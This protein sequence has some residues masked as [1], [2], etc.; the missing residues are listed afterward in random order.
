MALSDPTATAAHSSP[1]TS[2]TSTSPA[3]TRPQSSAASRASAAESSGYAR[4][5]V[6][7]SGAAAARACD[8]CAG[9]FLITLA[10]QDAILCRQ[11]AP[12]GGQ[13]IAHKGPVNVIQNR[14]VWPRGLDRSERGE[15][16]A[17]AR[18]TSSPRRSTTGASRPGEQLP[19]TRELARLADVNPLTA[20]RVYRRLRELGYLSATV[21]RGTFVRSLP[22]FASDELDDDWQ[23][24]ALPPAPAE[25]AR[26][27]APGGDARR[28]AAGRDLARRR[29][30]R[31][32]SRC[33]SPS[34]PPRSA[35]D[36]RRARA[37]RARLHRRR[38]RARAARP[39]G[40]LG[41]Q[42][43]FAADGEEIL[44]TTGARQGIDL[45]ARAVVREDDVVCVESPTYVGM[46][47]SFEAT[48]ARV[49]GIP[50]DAD[51]F[52]VDALERVLARY[53]VKL[54]ALQPAC[55]NPTGRHLVGRAPRA[56]ARA[57]AR[58][59]VLRARGR[60]LR[61]PRLRRRAAERRC[62]AGRPAT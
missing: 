54:V 4:R 2:A 6:T 47:S 18:A 53:P 11:Y 15:R 22:P 13:T 23:A 50:S 51:G 46:L 39:L 55:H 9:N 42:Q 16:H 34:S 26:A 38:G 25:R 5:M 3:G 27:R 59:V 36:L 44:V 57:G 62:A 19:P 35:D 31:R 60:R 41:Q 28:R 58:A 24:V 43:G 14:F 8:V 37:G 49:I 30:A 20:A 52:D 1:S 33:P 21:G 48:G 32:S 7:W 17:R 45:V 61:A 10:S 29:A 56:A 12:V 40:L